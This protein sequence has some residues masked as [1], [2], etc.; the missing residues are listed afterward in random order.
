[1]VIKILNQYKE[2]GADALGI[3][4]KG[5][6]KETIVLFM[7]SFLDCLRMNMVMFQ[8]MKCRA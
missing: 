8:Q 2:V 6:R 5:K 4:L 1:M 3:F 7:A